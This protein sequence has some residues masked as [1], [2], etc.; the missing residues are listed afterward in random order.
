MVS[1]F[2]PSYISVQKKPFRVLVQYLFEADVHVDVC[3]DVGEDVCSGIDVD[4]C[5]DVN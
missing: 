2:S 3:T 4:F 1:Y 5:I